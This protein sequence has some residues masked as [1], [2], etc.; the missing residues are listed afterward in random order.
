MTAT[1]ALNDVRTALRGTRLSLRPDH[2]DDLDGAYAGATIH[3]DAGSDI[4]GHPVGHLDIH[5]GW[6]V[7][8]TG[9]ARCCD[10]A[11]LGGAR[12]RIPADGPAAIAD[13]LT[14]AFAPGISWASWAATWPVSGDA[15]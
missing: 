1:A 10:S 11:M 3:L 9:S 15:G 2:G 13:W 6:G 8:A 12:V 14:R 5:R 4:L 7:Q